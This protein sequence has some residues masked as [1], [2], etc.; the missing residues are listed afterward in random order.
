LRTLTLEEH[1]VV[2]GFLN[3]RSAYRNTV[4]EPKQ[5]QA[6]LLDLGD[7][8][9]SAMDETGVDRQVLS[10]AA[11]GFEEL[12][13][14]TATPLARDV[15]DELASAVS[16][17]PDRLAGF[18]CLA[19]KDP[20]KAAKELERWVRTLGFKGALLNRTTGSEFLDQSKSLP[21]LEAAAQSLGV[22]VYLHPAPPP[23]VVRNSET[24]LGELE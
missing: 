24:V 11:M 14:A 17:R 7:G 20:T 22:P 19:M 12:D 9:I 21:V 1:F 13:V 15:N 3:P 4:P 5:L 8:R 2:A 10:L 23:G 6:Q 18:A 16:A